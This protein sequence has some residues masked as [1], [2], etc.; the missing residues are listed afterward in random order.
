MPNPNRLATLG[1]RYTSFITERAWLLTVACFIAVAVLVAGAARLTTNNDF[2]AFFGADNP[3]L[4]ALEDFEARYER[5]Q[6][7]MMVVLPE[8]PDDVFTPDNLRLIHELTALGWQVPYSRRVSSLTNY[9]H[10]AAED[11]TIRVAALLDDTQLLD[12]PQAQAHAAE[13]RLI[14]LS[15]RSLINRVVSANGSATIVNIGLTLPDHQSGANVEVVNFVTSKLEDVRAR[16]PN[17]RIE[18]G[19]TT[20]TDV[21]LG[22]AVRRDVQTLVGL[23]YFVIIVG[24]T[25]LLRHIGGTVA[26][27]LVITSSIGITMGIFGWL[28]TTLEPT[29]GFVPS[30]VMTIAVADSVHILSTFYYEVRRGATQAA[31]VAEALRINAAPVALTSIT[32]AIGV[33]MLNFSDSPP[34]QELG[35]MVAVGVCAAWVLSMTL[36]PALLMLMP[37][38]TPHSG[39]GMEAVMDCFAEWLIAH[40]S[41]VLI[42]MSIIIVAIAAQIPRNQIGEQWHAY[43]DETFDVQRAIEASAKHMGGLHIIQYNLE[44][45]DGNEINNPQ[46]LADVEAFG[47]WLL[48]QP[49]VVNADRLTELLERLNMNLHGDDPAFR[50]VPN[51]RELAAQLLFMYELSLP[52]GQSLDNTISLDRTSTRMTVSLKRTTSAHLLAFDARTHAWL[53]ANTSHLKPVRGT[54]IDLIFANINHRN[55]NSLLYGMVF[56]LMGISL[57]LIF[58]LRSLKL[59]L[60]SLI[61]NLAP[62]GLAYGTWAMFNGL[63]DLSASVVIC[64]SIGIVVDDTVHFLSK[65]RR[66]RDEQNMTTTDALRYAFHTVGVALTITTTVLVAGFAVLTASHFAPSVTTGALMA[67]TLA[68]ALVVDFLFLPPLLI[69]ADR[70]RA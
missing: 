20:A 52:M 3:E 6:N 65:Y 13:I 10:T 55:I 66:A 22:Q 44:T 60:L 24:L 70:E 21:A 64:M 68:F 34:Y 49:E 45:G 23:S 50:K 42:A 33:L 19:G 54:G 61:T 67:T 47:R 35:N 29:A 9:Q 25:V 41:T 28:G 14:A 40:K 63:I 2:R 51:T 58:A 30:I 12:T 69:Y 32:T 39:Q 8:S 1:A 27:L 59:G 11:D 5:Q 56:A 62:A 16:Y 48:T 43:F 31:A 4:A 17:T 36:L 26:T 57:L 18:V 37:V 53:K 46:Y 15:E 38:R 7:V